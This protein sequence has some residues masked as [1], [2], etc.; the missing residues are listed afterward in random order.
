M[1]TKLE[2]SRVVWRSK[3]LA[4]SFIIG[5]FEQAIPWSIDLRC[6]WIFNLNASNLLNMAAINWI[7]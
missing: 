3:R 7:E 4:F 6:N 5:V 2:G 1:L